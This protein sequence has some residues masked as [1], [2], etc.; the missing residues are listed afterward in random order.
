MRFN[1]LVRSCLIAA[2]AVSVV[3][4]A[5]CNQQGGR[6]RPPQPGDTAVAKV[7]GETVW[8]S[9]VKREAVAQGLIGEGEP[10]DTTSDLFRRVLDEVVDQ[11]LLAREAVKRGLDKS[12]LAQRR[13]AAARERIL[14]DMLVENQVDNAIDENAVKALYD[15]QL[16]LAKQSEEIRARLILVKTQPEGDA[17]AKLL[18]TGASFEALA[19]ERSIDQATRF[20][21]GD[22]GYFTT[23]VMPPAYATAL[24]TA[25]AGETVGPFQ[26]DAGW[27]VLR[28][29]DR[30]KEQ[31][32]SIEEARP[33]ILRF[34]T[35]DEVRQ[36]LQKLRGQAKV[37]IMI[38]G[39]PSGANAKE[40]ASAPPPSLRAAPPAAATTG[41]SPAVS[42]ANATSLP[43]APVPAPTATPSQKA[44][45]R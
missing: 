37:Q 23:D 19:M 9:D 29:E 36:L 25:K 3:A 28:V 18:S 10:L 16:R 33:Q 45:A 31:P 26:T 22:L 42:A 30:R 4:V 40:P 39:E 43:S 12:P 2:A 8:A 13:L 5:A 11:K 15:E 24:K 20:N 1:Q 41:V 32:L 6:D 27:A 38:K 44:P 17:V 21:G 14:G 34:L 7:Q 35:Y